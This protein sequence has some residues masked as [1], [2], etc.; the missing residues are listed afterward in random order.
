MDNMRACVHARRRRRRCASSQACPIMKSQEYPSRKQWHMVFCANTCTRKYI[1]ILYS[2]ITALSVK[3][4]SADDVLLAMKINREN[5]LFYAFSKES[6][7]TDRQTDWLH[8]CMHACIQWYYIATL[9]LYARR[10]RRLFSCLLSRN[11]VISFAFFLSLLGKNNVSLSSF[12]FP[13]TYGT[14]TLGWDYS[15]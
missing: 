8:E 10:R 1:R 9:L 7:Q 12:C 4:R 15:A 2:I 11:S 14:C 5:Q 3:C 6:S 13:W